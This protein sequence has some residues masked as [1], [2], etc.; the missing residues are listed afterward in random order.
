MESQMGLAHFWNQGDLVTHTTAIILAL[1]SLA[2]WSVIISKVMSTLRASRSQE[3]ALTGF[4]N[5]CAAT[6]HPASSPA[7]R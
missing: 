4:W 3:R 2:S 7:W 5:R 1:L 6:T